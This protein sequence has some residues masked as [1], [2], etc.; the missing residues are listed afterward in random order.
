MAKYDK[1]GK[2]IRQTWLFVDNIKVLKQLAREQ[3]YS[4]AEMID[5]MI[6]FYNLNKIKIKEDSH[7]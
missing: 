5:E 2:E 4:I 6:K 3:R 1:F 7:G